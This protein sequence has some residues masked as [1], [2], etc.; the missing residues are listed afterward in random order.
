MKNKCVVFIVV[1]VL[2][3]L[4]LSVLGVKYYS[5]RNEL[6]DN[7]TIYCVM[8]DPSNDGKMELF[9][10][11]KD[12]QVYR[13]S[14]VSTY[15]MTDDYKID[16]AKELATKSNEKY[17]GIIQNVW[18]DGKVRVS[19]EIYNLDIMNDEDFNSDAGL[20]VKDLKSKTR[21]QIIE[22]INPIGENGSY[23]CN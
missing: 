5:V 21:Q 11:F 7:K 8:E 18:T 1:I 22:S 16:V 4:V 19:T 13:Y 3:V 23:K 17:K 15:K 10:D 2:L 6:K 14:I 12:N 20:L 9:Y